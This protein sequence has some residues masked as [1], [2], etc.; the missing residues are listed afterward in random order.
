MRHYSE[1]DDSMRACPNLA[2]QA[3]RNL[4]AAVLAQAVEDFLAGPEA[5]SRFTPHASR[6]RQYNYAR[7]MQNQYDLMTTRVQRWLFEDA[8]MEPGAFL[9]IC[10][11]LG[12]DPTYVRGRARVRKA[13]GGRAMRTFMTVQ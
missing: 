13:V 11:A 8:P 2:E 10:D 3:C 1:M 5:L 7:S 9:W 6:S 12:L 4:W